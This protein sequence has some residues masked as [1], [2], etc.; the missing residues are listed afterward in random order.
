MI[1]LK[2]IQ[3]SPNRTRSDYEKAILDAWSVDPGFTDYLEL[4]RKVIAF[5]M[6]KKGLHAGLMENFE[7]ECVEFELNKK[8]AAFLSGS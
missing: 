5:R 2:G 8:L 6:R 7:Q 4:L 1:V 3:Q